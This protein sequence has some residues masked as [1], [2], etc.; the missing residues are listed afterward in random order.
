MPEE[1]ERRERFVT[2]NRGSFEGEFPL[3]QSSPLYTAQFSSDIHLDIDLVYHNYMDVS[4]CAVRVKNSVLFVV[5]ELLESNKQ[6]RCPNLSEVC[7]RDVSYTAAVV[8]Q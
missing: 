2:R 1:E 3:A 6:F 8:R 5:V 4:A 7:V